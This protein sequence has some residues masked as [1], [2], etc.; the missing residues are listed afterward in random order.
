MAGKSQLEPAAGPGKQTAP[1]ET[2][3]KISAPNESGTP[4]RDPAG[5]PAAGS[6]EVTAQTMTSPML[7]AMSNPLRRRIIAVLA[8]QDYARATDLAEQLGVAANK[9]SYHLRT[10]A[11]AGMIQEA[12][13][14]A[15]DNRDRVWQAAG[16]SYRIGNPEDPVDP[17]EEYSLNAYLSQMELDQHAALSR[18][19]AWAPD[20][21][22]GRDAETKAELAVGTLRLSVQDA[23]ELF[24][25]VEGVL[26]NARQLH[27]APGEPGVKIWDY[28]FMAVREDL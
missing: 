16:E 20:F 6:A 4:A 1:K 11:D 2:A 9:L 21:A 7:R 15:R 24:R 26:K 25:Q 12:P 13:Q 14:Y 22:T 18:V 17:S 28:T 27:R 8:A 5:K 19:L 23:E 3:S 10:L